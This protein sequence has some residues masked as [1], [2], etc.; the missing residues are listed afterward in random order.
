MVSPIRLQFSDPEP[1]A[2]MRLL[3]TRSLRVEEFF[4]DSALP[5]YAILSHRWQDEEVSLQQLRDGQATAMRG[6]KKLADSCSQAR[7]DGFDYVWIDTCCIDKTSSAELSEALN[8]MYQW[9]QRANICYAYLFD[10]DETLVAEQ[11]SF[12]RS[13]WFTRGWTLQ[14]L[15]A[16]ATVEFFNGTWQRLGSKLKLKD[17]ICEVTGIHPGVLTGELELQ[18]FSVAQ[19]MSW[20]ARRTTAKVEDRAYSLLGIFGINMPMLYGE[21]ER[22]F[23]RLQEE[24]MKQSDDHSLFAWKSADPNHRGLFARSPEAFAESGHLVQAASKWNIKPYSLT[25]MGLSIELPMVEWS[26]GVY[27]AALDCETEGVQNSRVGIFLSDLPEKNQYARVM[28]DGVDLPRFATS[29]QSQYRHIYVRQQIRGSLRPVE[30]EYGFWLR[31]IPRPSLSLDATFDVT[32]WNNKWTRQNM[33]FTIPKGE[34]GT[35]VVIRYKLEKGRTTNIKL[36]FD[37]KFNPVCQ[38]GGQ[39]YSPKTFGSPFRDTFQGIMATDW[40]NSR[41]EGV[42]VGDKQTG[43]NVDDFHRILILKETIKGKEMWVVYI[44]DYDEEAVWYQDRVCDGCNLVS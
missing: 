4:D 31:R 7:R 2:N 24:I 25:N 35:A 42:H 37:P 1:A 30:R 13:A 28:L 34:C 26:M 5:D 29:R 3:N 32:A 14:E 36:G 21:G 9:Y 15:L 27:L 38:F 33:V 22:A 8:S 39:Y 18:S 12:Y 20:A 16:P 11:S 40:M 10:V 6:Y 44:A 19:R 17:A 41:L 23:L 43:L